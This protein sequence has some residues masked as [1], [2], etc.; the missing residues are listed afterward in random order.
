MSPFREEV[1][2][3]YP[4]T[5]KLTSSRLSSIRFPELYNIVIS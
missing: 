1:P 3:V 5:L 2:H 4:V